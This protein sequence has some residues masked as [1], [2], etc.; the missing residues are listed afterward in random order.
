MGQRKEPWPSVPFIYIHLI[1]YPLFRAVIGV[2]VEICEGVKAKC[3]SSYAIVTGF[4][5]VT[6][7]LTVVHASSHSPK[8]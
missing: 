2:T 5:V 4:M 8:C 1:F 3:P 7:G 6:C